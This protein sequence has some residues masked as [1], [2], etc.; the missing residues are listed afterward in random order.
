MKIFLTLLGAALLSTSAMA[1]GYKEINSGDLSDDGLNPTPVRLK[2]GNNVIDGDYGKSGTVDRD[3]FVIKIAD[4]EQLSAIILDP[5]TQVGGNVSFIGVQKGRQVTVDPLG[6]SPEGLLGWTHY[7]T[8]DE[9]TDILPAICNGDGAK[10]CTP[11]LGPGRYAFWVQET[12]TCACHYRYIFKVTTAAAEGGL[13]SSTG[14][15]LDD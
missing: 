6:G 8:G 15:S 11:P 14:R 10:G 13:Q 4:G 12:G 2:V 5:R 3:Y 9:G 1:A 7:S